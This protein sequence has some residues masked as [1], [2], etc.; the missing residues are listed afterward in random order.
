L[1]GAHW[2]ISRGV[3]STDTVD[4]D[5]S[6]PSRG[7]DGDA[8]RNP[9]MCWGIRYRSVARDHDRVIPTERTKERRFVRLFCWKSGIGRESV[10][11]VAILVH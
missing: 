9:P 10:T 7:G 1:A 6:R 4:E 3:R 8:D 5:D 11:F 2:V